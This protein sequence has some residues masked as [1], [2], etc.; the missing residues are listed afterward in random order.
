VALVVLL[1]DNGFALDAASAV[2]QARQVVY[3]ATRRERQH[4]EIVGSLW[5]A[6]SVGLTRW[7]PD[8]SWTSAATSRSRA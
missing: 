4:V 1:A 3:L 6:A 7:V 2:E 8:G 5:A